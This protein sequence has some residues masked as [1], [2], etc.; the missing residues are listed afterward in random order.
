MVRKNSEERAQ[1]ITERDKRQE[2][3]EDKERE[4]YL[5][6]GSRRN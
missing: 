6:Y 5:K 4:V 2:V 3:L 1:L